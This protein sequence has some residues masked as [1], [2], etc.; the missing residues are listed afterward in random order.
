MQK[1]VRLEKT[2][3]L[4]EHLL[5][6]EEVDIELVINMFEEFVQGDFVLKILDYPMMKIRELLDENIVQKKL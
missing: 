2:I 6:V 1:K 3:L 4:K 5:L